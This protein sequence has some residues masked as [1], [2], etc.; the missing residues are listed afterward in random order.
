[1]TIA[2]IRVTNHDFFFCGKR[3]TLFAHHENCPSSAS[4]TGRRV[5]ICTMINLSFSPAIMEIAYEL[6]LSRKSNRHAAFISWIYQSDSVFSLSVHTTVVVA[7]ICRP[8]RSRWRPSIL[9]W[10]EK[11]FPWRNSY[12]VRSCLRINETSN[13]VRVKCADF[14]YFLLRF[15][16]SFAIRIHRRI[17]FHMRCRL[18]EIK[19]FLHRIVCVLRS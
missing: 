5:G 8:N 6:V 12:L 2:T 18:R 13:R 9:V 7:D 17:E 15:A 4:F 11:I 1:M 14:D 16:D 10:L 19:C 3:L